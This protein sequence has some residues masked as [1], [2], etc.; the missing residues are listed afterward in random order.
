M[1]YL[2]ASMNGEAPC[3]IDC[4]NNAE[5]RQEKNEFLSLFELDVNAETAFAVIS[6]R[7]IVALPGITLKQ[8]ISHLKI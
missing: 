5:L 2:V 7:D 3:V 1:T 4:G 8:K 6:E